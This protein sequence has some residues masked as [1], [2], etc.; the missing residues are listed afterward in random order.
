MS[1]KSK[2]V[3]GQQPNQQERIAKS[4]EEMAAII[5][6]DAKESEERSKRT[7]ASQTFLPTE[8]TIVS[9]VTVTLINEDKIKDDIISGCEEMVKEL[10]KKEILTEDNKNNFW[11][12]GP[13]N[14]LYTRYAK[15]CKTENLLEKYPEW[16]EYIRDTV[17]P[18]SLYWVNKLIDSDTQEESTSERS[19]EVDLIETESQ[20]PFDFDKALHT[21]VRTIEPT[22]HMTDQLNVIFDPID[23]DKL[24]EFADVETL[25]LLKKFIIFKV[26]VRSVYCKENG[27]KT[28]GKYLNDYI[29]QL[30]K[31]ITPSATECLAIAEDNNVKGND[32]EELIKQGF[33]LA[34]RK[35]LQENCPDLFEVLAIA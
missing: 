14:K 35:R 25:N 27:I 21:C 20:D 5:E 28:D 16:K 4:F 3:K 24:P 2:K 31:D 11:T 13:F 7:A 12:Q 6:A 32:M 18:C 29:V 23:K 10:I 8:K 33:C 30:I 15:V 9:D 19:S 17:I 34:M 1:K 22:Q 26:K